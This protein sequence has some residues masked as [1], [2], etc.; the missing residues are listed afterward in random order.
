MTKTLLAALLALSVLLPC[1]V[2][3]QQQER[4]FPTVPHN[5]YEALLAS[6][7]AFENR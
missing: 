1:M 3:A 2:R 5:G 7:K 4:S 6:R